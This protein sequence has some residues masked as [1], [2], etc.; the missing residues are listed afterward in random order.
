M[1]TRFKY[2]KTL[3]LP[4]S[5]GLQN[6]DR[7]MPLEDVKLNFRDRE[8]I[9]TEKLDGENTSMYCDH[10]HARSVYSGDHPSR[11]WVKALHGRIKNDIPEDWRI[12]GENCFAHH[13]IFYDKL[14]TYFYVFAIYNDKNICLE[15]DEMVYW[16]DLFDLKTVPILFKGQFDLE[17][18]KNLQNQLN[19]ETQEGYVIRNTHSFH[20]SDFQKNVAKFVRK[21]H[22]QTDQHWMSKPVVRNLLNH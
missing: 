8:V 14:E 22:V 16:C 13:S 9:A 19:L 18:I 6:D 1:E 5:P 17:F 7:L 4:W 21:G 11:S 10:I 3:H 15:W 20:Y 2:P 12:I